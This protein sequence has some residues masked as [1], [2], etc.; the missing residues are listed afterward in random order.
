MSFPINPSLNQQIV[1]GNKTYKWTG[2]SWSRVSTTAVSLAS[3]AVT[4]NAISNASVTADK[5]DPVLLSNIVTVSNLTA[6]ATTTYVSNEIANLVSSAPSTLNTLNELATA[7]GNDASFATTVATTLSTKAN[8][9]SLTT[10][11]VTE[12]TNLYFTNTRAISAFTSG[13]G[14]SIAANGRITG[15]S[16]YSNTD[17]QAYLGNISGALIPSGDEVYNIGSSTRKWA[18]LFLSGNTIVLG[19]TKIESS[20]DGSIRIKSTNTQVTSAISFA[21]NGYIAAPSGPLA[22]ASGSVSATPRIA[23]VRVTD[24]NYN[25]LDDTAANNG[26][27]G[28]VEINGANFDSGATVIVGTSTA[29]SVSFV[30]ST[31]LRVALPSLTSGTYPVYVINSDGSTATRINGLNISG[32]PTWNTASGSLGNFPEGTRPNILLNATSDTSVTYALVS[33]SS[34]PTNLSL[35]S[36]GL[37]TGNLTSQSSNTTYNFSISATDAELQNTNRSFSLTALYDP[38]TWVSPISNTNYIYY[39]TRNTFITINLVA[40]LIGQSNI[41]YSSNGF[42]GTSNL[43]LIGNTISGHLPYVL[44]NDVV[45]SSVISA[46]NPAGRSSNI[47]IIFVVNAPPVSGQIKY[48]T[49]GTYTFVVPKGISSVSVVAVGGGGGG[50]STYTP[51]TSGGDSYFISNTCVAGLGGPT[52]GGGTGS[53]AQGGC[54]VG[55][56]GGQGGGGGAA[57]AACGASYAWG[58]GGGGAGGYGGRGGHG[59]AGGYNQGGFCG[60]GGGGT[61]DFYGGVGGGGVGLCGQG[62]DGVVGGGGSGGCN[63]IQVKGGL[64]GGGSSVMRAPGL[65]GSGGGL[66]WKNN[67][68]VVAGQSYTVCV[69]AYGVNAP[70]PCTIGCGADGGVRI[71]WS[72]PGDPVRCYPNVNVSTDL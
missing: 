39:G 4:T 35:N 38:P 34:L 36:N 21:S 48:T 55:D 12:V 46:S 3:N 60:G 2:F 30:N 54:W 11:N 45:F 37:I 68:P 71:V 41:S 58:R 40:N 62:P 43:V 16:Q 28:F 32:F 5:I 9:A 44:S 24:S 66:G 59:G 7:L 13:S 15:A 63:G 53:T 64:H 69:G 26:A 20:G 10:A 19:Q 31:R 33:G 65:G 29:S 52:N 14:I 8:T 72:A 42:L 17:V 27:N 47:T 1:K 56:G 67:I 23:N 6:Y 49:A 25:Y 57:A 51:G 70:T 61:D 50:S 22:T 18:N